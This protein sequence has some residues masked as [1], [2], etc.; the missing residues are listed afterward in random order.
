[1]IGRPINHGDGEGLARL[2]VLMKALCLRR[3]KAVLQD[4]LPPK[5]V[6]VRASPDGGGGRVAGVV[7]MQS[8]LMQSQSACVCF[9]YPLLW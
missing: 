6:Y 3:T 7:L 8:V 4:R 1:M 9:V 2:R 5:T